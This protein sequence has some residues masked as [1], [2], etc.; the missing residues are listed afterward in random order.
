MVDLNK[1]I[2]FS[3]EKINRLNSCL[4][5]IGN[6]SL[7]FVKNYNPKPFSD[8][9]KSSECFILLSAINLNALFYDCLYWF[10]NSNQNISGKDLSLILKEITN[11]DFE[12]IKSK[13]SIINKIRNSLCHNSTTEN[14][15]T[16][17]KYLNEAGID[18]EIKKWN[19]LSLEESNLNLFI[20]YYITPFDNY[21]DS[22]I[23]FFDNST[24]SK[25]TYNENTWITILKS[26][27]LNQQFL[28]FNLPR[29]LFTVYDYILVTD[30]SKVLKNKE[31]QIKI[32]LNRFLN[33]QS[34][35][36]SLLINGYSFLAPMDPDSIISKALISFLLL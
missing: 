8:N 17:T 2:A 15:N 30:E 7:F 13:S 18:I 12:E 33:K 16:I 11:I 24:P 32:W 26:A 19:D 31:K 27:Y 34:S 3:R 4:S 36:L 25:L 35:E 14:F 1:S 22:L 21:F 29:I 28:E 23:K 10:F 9:L 5:K 20:Q 6:K